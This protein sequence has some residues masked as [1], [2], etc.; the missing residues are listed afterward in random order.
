MGST[1]IL[2][3]EGLGFN[4]WRLHHFKKSLPETLEESK[5]RQLQGGFLMCREGS[6]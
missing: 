3:A 4:P 5:V 1:H 2:H 6:S